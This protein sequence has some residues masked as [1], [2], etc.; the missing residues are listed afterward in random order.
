MEVQKCKHRD[1]F[2]CISTALFKFEFEFKLLEEEAKMYQSSNDFKLNNDR[3]NQQ[4][5]LD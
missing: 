3:T 5:K 4:G 2:S 1:L